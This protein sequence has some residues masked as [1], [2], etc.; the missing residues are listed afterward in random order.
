MEESSLEDQNFEN[1]EVVTPDEEE[2][3]IQGDSK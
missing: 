2:V 3:Y 1:S